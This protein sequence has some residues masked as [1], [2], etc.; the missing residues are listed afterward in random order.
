[1]HSKVLA[2]SLC[3]FYAE[4]YN[5]NIT[6]LRPF[7]LYGPNQTATF[8]I[9]HIIR[10]LLNKNLH[11]ISVK[12]LRPKRDYL[13]IDDLLEAIIL[14][15]NPIKKFESYNVGYG[16]SYSVMELV[17]YLMEIT[18][19]HKEVVS[20]QKIRE[21]EILDVIAD[22]QKIKSEL[23]WEP[24]TTIQEGLKKTVKKKIQSSHNQQ[25]YDLYTCQN[26]KS[27]FFDYQQHSTSFKEL[28]NHISTTRGNFTAN[29]IPSKKWS[30][31]VD[32][33]KKLL[34]K[35]PSSVLD[36]GCRTGDFLLHFDTSTDCEGVELSDHFA[37]I[38]KQR[39]LTIYNDFLENIDFKKKYDIVSAYAIM[40]HLKNPLQFIDKLDGIINPSGILVILIPTHQCLKR[41]WFDFFRFNWHMY[42]PPEH[43]NFY[44]RHF[45]DKYLSDRGF[46]LIK[47][48]YTSGGMISHFQ[49]I[50][51]LKKILS[52]L[53]EIF[54][55]SP[56][57]RFP[58]F[59]HMYSYYVLKK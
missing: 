1:M 55:N 45:L 21:N 37:E 40:E 22:I 34:G 52:K 31:Q 58:I 49:N 19:I 11:T 15:L 33:I 14:T 59:D 47:R 9:P 17:K 5:L 44:S 43:L 32:I 6:V 57:N 51:F 13:Y 3:K 26:C 7:N 50:S 54:D 24:K 46:Q 20:E 27:Y 48:F 35:Y 30:K 10:Q 28:Y 23:G 2:E 39:G 56:L 4:Y 42:S 18:N 41:K 29:L 25:L 8:L 12:D 38:G 16:K 53:I 36:I